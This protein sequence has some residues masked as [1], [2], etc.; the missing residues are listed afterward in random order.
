MK[1]RIWDLPTRL[2]HWALVVCVI[3]QVITAGIGG[4]VM[5]WHFRIGYTVISLLLFR[6]VWGLVGG[7]WSRFSSFVYAPSTVLA[8]VRGRSNDPL[9]QVGHSPLGSLSVLAMLLVLVLQVS[10]GLFAD[11]EISNQGPLAKHVSTELSLALTSYH[12]NVGKWILLALVLLHIGAIVFYRVR[13]G[14]R[15]TGAMITGDMDLARGDVPASRDTAASRALALVL[16]V[17]C[18]ALVEWLIRLAG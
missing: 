7:R 8:Y 1:V 6:L 10:A 17:G 3:A 12:K 15:L 5:Q 2:F 9:H 4:N 14:R 16:L 11:D 13:R 18:V